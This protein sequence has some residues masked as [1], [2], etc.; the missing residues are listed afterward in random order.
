MSIKFNERYKVINKI[1]EGSFGN[2]FMGINELTNTKVAIKVDSSNSIIL[3]NEARIY[4]LLNNIRGV[5]KMKQYGTYKEYNYLIIDLLGKSLEYYKK[6]YN[7]ICLKNVLLIGIQMFQRIRDIHNLNIIHRDIKPENFM[8]GNNENKD[9]LY[10]IDFGLSKLY[11]KNNKHIDYQVNKKLLGTAKYI[12]INIHKGVIGSRRDDLESIMYVL[13]YLLIDKLPWDNL[14]KIENNYVDIL[15][16]K[17]H[18]NF[19]KYNEIPYEFIL[20]LEYIKKLEF[21]E[22]PNYDYIISI[23]L[24]VYKD[25]KFLFDNNY[26]WKFQFN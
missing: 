2:I 19:S 7:K 26:E 22:D 23:I 25:K 6:K 11:F 12:S 18:I 15:Y 9:L 14:T 10:L 1:G 24:N 20:I 5:P 8:F 13:I 3:K 4:N 17:E 16:S 21:T